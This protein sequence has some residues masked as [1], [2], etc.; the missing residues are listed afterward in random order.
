M[1]RAFLRPH[2]T[3]LQGERIP[4]R[5][6]EAA[7]ATTELPSLR[8]LAQHLIRDLDAVSAGL[9][10]QWN[11]GIAEGHVNRINMLERQMTGRGGI[12]TPEQTSPVDL[13]WRVSLEN[14]TPGAYARPPLLISS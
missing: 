13:T 3:H 8:H 11:S 9:T 4:D 2:D 5:R 6:I 10:H 7:G 14:R 1:A 12:R